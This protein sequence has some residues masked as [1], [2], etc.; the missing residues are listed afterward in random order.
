MVNDDE[1]LDGVESATIVATS[2]G[3]IEGDIEIQITDHENLDSGTE[4]R[5]RFVRMLE[6]RLRRANQTKQS[7]RRVPAGCH[8]GYLG[9]D[10]KRDTT[11]IRVPTTVDNPC[12]FAVRGL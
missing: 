8:P 3:I 2:P 9:A 12:G 4:S 11:E 5:F 7:G 1:L 10:G 6:L